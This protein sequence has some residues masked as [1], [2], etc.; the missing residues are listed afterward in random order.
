MHV[1]RGC[2]D[3]KSKWIE[4]MSV[5]EKCCVLCQM[6]TRSCRI[7]LFVDTSFFS[8]LKLFLK[9]LPVNSSSIRRRILIIKR[10]SADN[11]LFYNQSILKMFR[12]IFCRFRKMDFNVLLKSEVVLLNY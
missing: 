8:E 7:N 3:R 4:R 5:I 11:I 2:V 9:F 10:R 6:E 12:G 1:M